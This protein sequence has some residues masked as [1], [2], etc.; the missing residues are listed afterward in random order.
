VN[1]I[2]VPDPKVEWMEAE[3]CGTGFSLYKREVIEA[4]FEKFSDLKYG[5]NLC[6]LFNPIVE[7]DRL[8]SDDYAFCK[9]IREAG[10]KVMVDQHSKFVHLGEFAYGTDVLPPLQKKPQG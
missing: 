7:T 3:F 10:F 8:L 4:L 9:R 1:P 6:G 5:P 2:G